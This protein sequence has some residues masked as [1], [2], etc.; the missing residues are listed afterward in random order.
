MNENHRGLKA[1]VIILGILIFVMLGVIVTTILSRASQMAEGGSNFKA[2]GELDMPLPEGARIVESLAD[3][4]RLILRLRDDKGAES[5]VIVD[6][7]TGARLGTLRLTP[8]GQ[9]ISDGAPASP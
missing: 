8:S 2:F 5:M 7:A 4:G 6:L 9:G 1:V 3:G